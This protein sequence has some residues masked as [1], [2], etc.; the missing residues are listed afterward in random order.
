MALVGYE[1]QY[2]ILIMWTG[3]QK[4]RKERGL[5]VYYVEIYLNTILIEMLNTVQKSV[6]AKENLRFYKI[7][8]VVEK[9]TGRTYLVISYIVE[10]SVGEYTLEN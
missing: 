6:E 2:Y 9:S 10:T 7:V 5:N 1:N 3:Q 4:A 8:Y